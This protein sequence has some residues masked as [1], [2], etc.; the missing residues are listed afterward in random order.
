M[1]GLR[2]SPKPTVDDFKGGLH[3]MSCNRTWRLRVCPRLQTLEARDVPGF[4]APMDFFAGSNPEGL[5]VADLNGD[6]RPDIVVTLWGMDQVAV[7]LG[8]GTG[9]FGARATYPTGKHPIGVRVAD[10]NS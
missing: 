5:A 6:R 8:D 2:Y 4:L 7:L 3:S 1:T 9:A 10:V